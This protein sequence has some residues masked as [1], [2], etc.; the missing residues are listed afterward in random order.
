MELQ[1]KEEM[2]DLADLEKNT[3][4][5]PTNLIISAKINHPL[6]SG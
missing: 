3:N 4:N 1:K 6:K 5:A 2:N